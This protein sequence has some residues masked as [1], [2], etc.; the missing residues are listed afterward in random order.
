M[1]ASALP[2][3]N[4]VLA[5]VAHPDDESFGLGGVLHAF[6]AS[7]A[8]VS[9]LC[10]THGEASTLHG[11]DGD[12]VQVRERE[13]ADAAAVLGL[14]RVQLLGFPD[15]GLAEVDSAE[16]EA[17]IVAA[18]RRDEAAGLV[19]FDPD[20]VT[21]HPDHR[22]ATEVALRAA[23]EAGMPVLGWTLPDEVAAT[24]REEFGAPFSGHGPADIDLVV[25]V[26]RA[27]QRRA[28]DCHPSQAVPGSVLWRRLDLLGNTEHLRWL[29]RAG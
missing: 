28:V 8:R 2:A 19:V 13:L 17:V 23:T 1:V 27:A 16:L 26:D 3:W 15:G 11:V 14:D 25:E 7:G 5:V 10:L 6:V 21:G 24:L 4:S 22:R 9:V 12:L 20:G 18:I 29:R